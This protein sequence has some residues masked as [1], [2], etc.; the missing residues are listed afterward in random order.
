MSLDKVIFYVLLL[1][2]RIIERYNGRQEFSQTTVLFNLE[3]HRKINK[4]HIS[5]P[6]PLPLRGM[7]KTSKAGLWFNTETFEHKFIFL[8]KPDHS[9]LCASLWNYNRIT[10]SECMN[11]YIPL[12][13]LDLSR[14]IKTPLRILRHALR[15]MSLTVTISI[16]IV[17][18]V[19][20]G[21]M[22]MKRGI[23]ILVFILFTADSSLRHGSGKFLIFLIPSIYTILSKYTSI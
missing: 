15:E 14:N 16:L 22:F 19:Y 18:S 8:N 23:D 17:N 11:T 10:H 21:I 20:N 12:I 2:D 5:L 3:D 9:I 13:W 1:G 6:F 7:R 4:E